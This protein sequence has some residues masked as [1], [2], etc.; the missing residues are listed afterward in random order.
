MKKIQLKKLTFLEVLH[1]NN[2]Y[3]LIIKGLYKTKKCIIKVQ[4]L[5]L[6]VHYNKKKNEYYDQNYNKI[7]SELA[8]KLHFNDSCIP[9]T[10]ICC[11]KFYNRESI[12]KKDFLKEISSQLIG[13]RLN[14]APSIYDYGILTYKD[15]VF[16]IIAMERMDMNFKDFI[17][18]YCSG[19]DNSAKNVKNK[20][21]DKIN[22]L[23]NYG[24]Y[25]G[26]LQFSNIGLNI[27]KDKDN[28]EISKCVLLDWFFSN[29]IKSQSQILDD[30][31]R[32]K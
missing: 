10:L 23:H 29:E 30:L 19:N 1:K 4:C 27:N 15:I 22:I 11:D 18:K 32:Y 8:L 17:N 2:S 12:T 7:S 31:R 25:H 26:D 13:I 3:G 16:G 14:I 6:G 20:I 24:Y 5:R 28:R 21:I 9:N